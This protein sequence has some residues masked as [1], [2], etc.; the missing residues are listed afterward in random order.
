MG[1][2]GRKQRAQKEDKK[3]GE[4]TGKNT[5]KNTGEKTDKNTSKDPG[6]RA[7][8]AELVE[9]AI[10]RIEKRMESDE[11]KAS[12]GDF[13]RLLQLHKELQ[14]DQPSE[15]KITWIEPDG[16]EYVSEK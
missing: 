3:T 4:K 16:T 2:Q 15:I 10:Q 7:N 11:M 13:I 14:I 5:S 8:K 12:F 1:T 9:K 6:R